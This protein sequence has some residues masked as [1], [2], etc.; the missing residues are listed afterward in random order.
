MLHPE[1]LQSQLVWTRG[2][3]LPPHF[4]HRLASADTRLGQQPG[5]LICRSVCGYFSVLLGDLAALMLTT[6]FALC[7]FLLLSSGPRCVRLSTALSSAR[8]RP[9]LP[10]PT[11]SS[12]QLWAS[13]AMPHRSFNVHVCRLLP[14]LQFQP[15]F[16]LPQSRLRVTADITEWLLCSM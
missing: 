11:H 16:L 7:S 6:P 12:P 3:W 10:L 9:P 8:R 13:R 5:A 15:Y 4:V 1:A 14:D 2:A